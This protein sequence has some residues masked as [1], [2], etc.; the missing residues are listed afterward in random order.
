MESNFQQKKHCKIKI[1]EDSF[2]QEQ[3]INGSIRKIEKTARKKSQ[4]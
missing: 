3:L 1:A 2:D 4:R